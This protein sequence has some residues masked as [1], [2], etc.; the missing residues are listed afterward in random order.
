MS[1]RKCTCKNTQQD[2][3][4]GSQMRVFND[5]EGQSKCTSCSRESTQRMPSKIN[6]EVVVK[7]DEQE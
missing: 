1:I 7:E 2:A 5:G 3:L 6:H 4:H